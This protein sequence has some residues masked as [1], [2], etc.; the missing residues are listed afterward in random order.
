MDSD[1]SAPYRR[2][3]LLASALFVFGAIAHGAWHWTLPSMRELQGMTGDQWRLLFIFNWSITAVFAFLGS[4]SVWAARNASLTASQLR[5]LCALIGGLAL[6]RLG[7]QIFLPIPVALLGE[8]TNLWAFALLAAW[9]AIL[10]APV[11]RSAR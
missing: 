3:L 7:I 10:L 6:A 11:V 8:H 1:R 4:L 9:V 2:S 5:G